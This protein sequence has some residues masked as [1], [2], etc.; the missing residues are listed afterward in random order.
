MY[1][2]LTNLLN[3]TKSIAIV[4][5]RD[6]DGDAIGSAL[7]LKLILKQKNIN[8]VI[9]CST[10]IPDTYDFLPEFYSIKAEELPGGKNN[11]HNPNQHYTPV[12]AIDSADLKQIGAAAEDLEVA[13][14]IDHHISN[15]GY[16]KINIIQPEAS[17][18]GEIIYHIALALKVD[19]TPQIASCLYVSISTDTGHFKYPNTTCETFHITSNLVDAGADPALIAHQLYEQLTFDAVRTIGQGLADMK[20][21]MDGRVIWSSLEN[22]SDLGPRSLID[23][24]REVDTCEVAIVFKRKSEDETKVS[25]RS[26]TDFDVRLLAAKFGGGGHPKASG[27]TIYSS[28]AEAEKQIIGAIQKNI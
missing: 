11:N 7:A 16:A 15:P 2:D 26:K 6:P 1:N 19:I 20:Q 18:A 25:L 5:H 8:S 27:C 17:A 23:M 9:Y 21:T 13:V 3:N 24:I 10:N 28:L 12:I 14:N 22:S 4:I